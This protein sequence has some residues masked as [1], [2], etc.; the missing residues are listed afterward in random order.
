MCC[1]HDDHSCGGHGGRHR[2][3]NCACV[4]H[5]VDGPCFWTRKEKLAYLD[6]CLETLKTEVKSVETRIA[7]LK[8]EK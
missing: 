3:N 7:A 2:G 5:D 8:E 1:E 4:G 6:E